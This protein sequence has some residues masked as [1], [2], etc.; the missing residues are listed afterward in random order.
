MQLRLLREGEASAINMIV[1]ESLAVECATAVSVAHV[2]RRW[3]FFPLNALSDRVCASDSARG[4]RVA[5]RHRLR[6]SMARAIG[7]G[8][9]NG[10]PD[11][12]DL[13]SLVT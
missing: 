1:V 2:A 10:W 4:M 5:E 9:E 11:K 13:A 8:W 12:L 6:S 3:R 7:L